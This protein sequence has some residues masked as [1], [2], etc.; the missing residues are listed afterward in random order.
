MVSYCTKIKI[1]D[2][3]ENLN[4][5]CDEIVYSLKFSEQNF[6]TYKNYIGDFKIGP[7]LGISRSC[8]FI[9]T[10]C[11]MCKDNEYYLELKATSARSSYIEAWKAL[12]YK[13]LPNATM[14]YY[15]FGDGEPWFFSN[16]PKTKDKYYISVSK[17]KLGIKN[18]TFATETQAINALQKYL[19][20]TEK[21]ISKLLSMYNFTEIDDLDIL[22]EKWNYIPDFYSERGV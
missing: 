16:D 22:V 7:Q 5:F 11:T 17:N 8:N 10:Q 13:I 4:K 19:N 21:D 12:V 1:Y 15:C 20:T 18:Y 6:N 2:K 9:L 3:N 14:F